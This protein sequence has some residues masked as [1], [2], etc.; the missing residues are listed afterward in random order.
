MKR[1]ILTAIAVIAL[2]G[3][4]TGCKEGERL[5]PRQDN[6]KVFSSSLSESSITG[7]GKHTIII[8]GTAADETVK[9]KLPT[10]YKGKLKLED[11]RAE[12]KV[13][14]SQV[15]GDY[16]IQIN[17]EDLAPGHYAIELESEGGSPKHTVNKRTETLVVI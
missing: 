5:V 11:G 8:N 17:V 9:I 15:V 7:A 16:S 14:A 4:T 3:L 13:R 10:V 1:T 12:A 6:D 2:A